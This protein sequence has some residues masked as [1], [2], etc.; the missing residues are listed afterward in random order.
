LEKL[1]GFGILSGFPEA[2]VSGAAGRMDTTKTN[3]RH[4]AGDVTVRPSTAGFLRIGSESM[5]VFF[6]VYNM[7][8]GREIFS[9]KTER[10]YENQTQW[11]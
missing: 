2:P 9:R 1:H 5:V 8:P 6:G 11:S 7:A 10:H 4:R 3:T